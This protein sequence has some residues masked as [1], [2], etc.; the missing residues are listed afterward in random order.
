MN[1]RGAAGTGKT[2]TLQELNRGLTEARREAL[3]VAPTMSA[4]EELQ[5]VGFS[6]ATT[7]QRLLQ[8]QRVQAEARGKVLIVDEAG[9]ISG[10]QMTE[11][12]QLARQM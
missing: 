7:I 9:M 10:G 8:D 2:A 5:H 3:A 1:I 6:N 4:V 11:L 12:L